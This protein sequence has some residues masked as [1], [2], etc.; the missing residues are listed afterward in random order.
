MPQLEPELQFKLA[1]PKAAADALPVYLTAG[2]LWAFV[3]LPSGPA[4]YYPELPDDQTSSLNYPPGASLVRELPYSFDFLVENFFDVAHIPFAHHTLQSVRSDGKPMQ[5]VD[6][7]SDQAC[8]VEFVDQVR[9]KR[10]E[11]IMTFRPPGSYTLTVEQQI[12]LYIFCMPVAPGRSRVILNV[13]PKS[14]NGSKIFA[15]LPKWLLHLSSNIFLDSDLWVHD[16]ELAARGVDPNKRFVQPPI[17]KQVTASPTFSSPDIRIEK[18]DVLSEGSSPSNGIRIRS[19]EPY[20]PKYVILSKTG[21]VGVTSWRNWWRKRGMANSTV[22]GAAKALTPLSPQQQSNRYEGHVKYC[23]ACQGALKNAEL[24]QRWGV[25]L[26]ILPIAF[27]QSIWLRLLGITS[28]ALSQ[29][30]VSKV[31]QNLIGGVRGAKLTAAQFARVD[32]EPR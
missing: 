16:Q 8:N 10:R 5:V 29:V 25:L 19:L 9:G 20:Q 6:K 1:S 11:G 4:S 2:L 31:I 27:T 30:I 22:F 3:P 18:E 12:I 13:Y 21:D 7:S 17:S 28:Y 32:K 14:K 26:A 24:I 23:V 15:L